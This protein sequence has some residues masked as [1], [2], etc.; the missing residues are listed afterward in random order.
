MPIFRRNFLVLS[1]A[2]TGM[3]VAS[4]T[5][6][7]KPPETLTRVP[8]ILLAFSG[9]GRQTPPIGAAESRIVH[10]RCGRFDE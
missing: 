10:N 6:A 1:D 3:S 9:R 7:Q 8:T 5:P 4:P 2:A